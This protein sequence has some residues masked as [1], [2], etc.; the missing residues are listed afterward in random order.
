MA[1]SKDEAARVLSQLK[2]VIRTNYS[3]PPT[4]AAPV[5]STGPEHTRAVRALGKMNWPHAP[6]PHP[7]DAQGAG[8]EDQDPGRGAG[9]QL[10]AGAARHVLVL[11]A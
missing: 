4:T 8:R 9:L 1:G 7:P 5:V 10:R 2:R 11:G 6:R 3:N